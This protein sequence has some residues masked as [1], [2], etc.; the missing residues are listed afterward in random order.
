[1]PEQRGF[2]QDDH[3]VRTLVAVPQLITVAVFYTETKRVSLDGME[4][5]LGANT[6]RT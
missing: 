3:G 5:Q 2:V 6:A 1:M 4:K